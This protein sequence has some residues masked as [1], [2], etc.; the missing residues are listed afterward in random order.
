MFSFIK[1]MSVKKVSCNQLA[2]GRGFLV[3]IKEPLVSLMG[4]SD[5]LM[6]LK[7][8]EKFF[9]SNTLNGWM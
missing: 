1:H 3:E 6:R 8:V 2:L 9:L 5:E 7:L 4:L